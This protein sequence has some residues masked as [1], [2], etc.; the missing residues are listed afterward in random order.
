MGPVASTKFAGSSNRS[1]TFLN[2]GL[3]YPNVRR[4]Q[5]LIWIEDRAA[6]GRPEIRY[7]RHTIC[8]RGSVSTYDGV[9]EIVARSPKQI[10]IVR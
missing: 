4:V 2:V 3:P 5:V 10:Q 8:V 9:V 6:F 1:P 7:R